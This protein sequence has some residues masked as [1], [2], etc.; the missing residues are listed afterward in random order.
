LAADLPPNPKT[1]AELEQMIA[2]FF[3]GKVRATISPEEA[4]TEEEREN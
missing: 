4:V 3:A 1:S 2:D